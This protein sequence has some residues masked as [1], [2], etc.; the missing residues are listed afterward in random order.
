V[1]WIRLAEDHAEGRSVVNTV[2]NFLDRL[3]E[4]GFSRMALPWS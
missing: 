4:F 1:R 2:K 3:S